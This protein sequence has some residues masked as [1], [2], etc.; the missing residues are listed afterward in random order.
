MGLNTVIGTS[1]SIASFGAWWNG[2]GADDRP[3]ALALGLQGNAR[4]RGSTLLQIEHAAAQ[5]DAME[6][7]IKSAI[8]YK[9]RLRSQQASIAAQEGRT[10]LWSGD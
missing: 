4:L 2:L 10:N 1:A 5:G 6:Q 9:G 8:D 3:E 7:Q